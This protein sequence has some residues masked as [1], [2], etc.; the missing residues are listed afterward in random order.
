MSGEK[1]GAGLPDVSQ[2]RTFTDPRLYDPEEAEELA[3]AGLVPKSLIGQLDQSGILGV[4]EI[5]GRGFD[6]LRVT[7]RIVRTPPSPRGKPGVEPG[8]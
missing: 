5:L 8:M 7:D 3:E 2:G 6:V 1:Q 4:V